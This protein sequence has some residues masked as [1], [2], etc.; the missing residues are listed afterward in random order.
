MPD[1]KGK[2]VETEEVCEKVLTDWECNFIRDS[3]KH[4]NDDP[5]WKP[6]TKQMN[7]IDELYDKV[8]R[9]PY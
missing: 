5:K 3:L 7:I 4:I 9:S 8:C 6:S 2:I 1:L